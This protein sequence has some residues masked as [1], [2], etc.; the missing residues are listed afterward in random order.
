MAD[1]L[2]RTYPLRITFSDGEQPSAQKLTAIS[3]QARTGSNL[4]EYAVGDLWNE[5]GDDVLVNYPLQIPNLARLIGQNKLFNPAIYNLTQTFRFYDNIG[6]KYAGKSDGYL[7]FVPDGTATVE[8]AGNIVGLSS[9][10]ANINLNAKNLLF[11][12]T[13]GKVSLFHSSGFAGTEVIS[14]DVDPSNWISGDEYL[15]SVIPDPRQL[16]FTHCRIS[17][18]SGSTYYIHLP[19]RTALDFTVYNSDERP[20]RYPSSDDLTFATTPENFATSTATPYK[21]I[22]SAGAIA[23]AHAYYR[24]AFPVEVAAALASLT[25]GTGQVPPGLLYLWDN[26][27]KTIVRDA[28]F[29]KSDATSPEDEWTLIVTSSSADSTLA[30]EATTDESSTSYSNS[31]Y[32]LIC[33]GASVANTVHTLYNQMHT[34]QHDNTGDMSSQMYHNNL[35][36]RDP[37]PGDS[38][39]ALA[40]SRWTNDPHISLLSRV[41]TDQGRDLNSNAMLTDLIIAG[42]SIDADGNQLGTAGDSHKLYFG[43]TSGPSLHS[44]G[45][46]IIVTDT[47]DVVDNTQTKTLTLDG[48]ISFTHIKHASSD[49]LL[50][51]CG[52]TDTVSGSNIV[53]YGGSHSSNDWEIDYTADLHRFKDG[54]GLDNDG[55]IIEGKLTVGNSDASSTVAN[56]L[57]VAGRTTCNESLVVSG[58]IT[59]NYGDITVV[60]GNVIVNTGYVTADTYKSNATSI[61]IP[62]SPFAG[63]TTNPA[64]DFNSDATYGSAYL[65]PSS[66]VLIPITAPLVGTVTSCSIRVKGDINHSFELILKKKDYTAIASVVPTTV[67][68]FS[69]GGSNI[70]SADGVVESL[71]V[72]STGDEDIAND[73]LLWLEVINSDGS[74]DLYIYPGQVTF[75]SVDNIISKS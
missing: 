21:F 48:G 37:D 35:I 38:G 24:Y 29:Y 67:A 56:G 31:R 36:G 39:K 5:S 9:T 52:S 8:T 15:P 26:D 22:Q 55:V 16:A 60:S 14:Y 62:F 34:H 51:I 69:T 43:S 23:L 45:T 50:A 41:G 58:H 27:D 4:I 49:K 17:L 32:S 6:A 63:I 12:T 18:R 30:S 53:L 10:V 71:T 3:E 75:S 65:D 42:S 33:V 66:I 11:D 54:D 25:A 7:Q 74:N 40:P 19:P 59:S 44:D 61:T 57:L 73:E 13:T 70:S 47:L 64:R 1:K 2:R 68:S 72:V 28:I 46:N 20:D